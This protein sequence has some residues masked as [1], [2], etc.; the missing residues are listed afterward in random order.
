M[1]LLRNGEESVRALMKLEHFVKRIQRG[2]VHSSRGSSL[3]DI[4]QGHFAVIA[5]KGGEPKRFIVE[6]EYLTNPAFVKLLEE[7]EQ[8]FGLQQKGV[9][10]VPCQPEELEM[11]IGERRRMSTEW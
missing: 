5:A 1:A 3:R 11:I 10:S 6:L 7:A 9:L 4:K 8:E 2:V